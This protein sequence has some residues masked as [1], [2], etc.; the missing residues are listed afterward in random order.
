[1][2]EGFQGIKNSATVPEAWTQTWIGAEKGRL[3][4]YIQGNYMNNVERT[5]ILLHLKP[6]SFLSNVEIGLVEVK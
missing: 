2:M 1:M 4:I 5:L 6:L 3:R